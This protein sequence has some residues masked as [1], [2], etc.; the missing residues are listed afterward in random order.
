[1]AIHIGRR[2][3]IRTLVGAAAARP[4]TA[5]AQQPAMPVVG[6]LSPGSPEA[7]TGRANAVRQGLKETCRFRKLDSS[8]ST[9]QSRPRLLAVTLLRR[10]P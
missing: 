7:D 8:V 5:R 1:M 4:L 3:L 2:E 9:V 6:F 10:E